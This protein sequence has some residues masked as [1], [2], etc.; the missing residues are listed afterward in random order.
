MSIILTIIIFGIIVIIHEWGHMRA[1]KACG[2]FVEEFAV[3][4]GPKLC[5]FK[6]GD[7]LY[8]IRALPLG[9]FCRMKDETEGDKV[10]FL[11]VSVWKRMIICVA[12]PLM[13][14]VLAIAVMMILGMMQSVSTTQIAEIVENSAAAEAGL[15]KGDIITVFNG[16]RM[17]SSSDVN[18]AILQNGDKAADI[19]VKRGSQKLVLSIKPQY[20][21]ERQRFLIGVI[22]LSKGPLID[23]GIYSKEELASVPRAGV[24]ESVKSGI[25]DGFFTIKLTV[26]SIIMLITQSIPMSELSGPIG[27]TSIVGDTYRETKA[28]AGLAASILVLAN[29]M[30]LLSANLGIMNLLPIPALD[31]GRLLIYFVEVIR[32]KQ[33]PPEKEGMINLAGFALM[34]AL[35][36]FVAYNDV[37]KLIK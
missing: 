1:A 9:G 30:A 12:G 26:Q 34:M 31:G 18:L 6:K 17:H 7:T 5:G 37:I 29:I 2:V 24:I 20:D 28:E 3:G 15:E 10:G 13:N 35:A 36:I 8:T 21:A 4:M 25:Y 11:N 32:G 23:I 22:M 14:F 33:I 27:V 16:K 19:T